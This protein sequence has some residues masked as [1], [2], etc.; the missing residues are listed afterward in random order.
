MINKCADVIVNWLISCDVLEKADRELYRYAVYSFLFSLYPLLLAVLF[1]I[2][3][4]CIMQAIVVIMPFMIIR[5]FSGGY[6]LKNSLLCLLVSCVLLF[7]CILLSFY[8]TCGWVLTAVTVAAAVSLIC[9]SPID[10]ENRVLEPEE[11][12]RYKK[13]TTGLVVCC[14]LVNGLFLFLNMH[15]LSVCISIG[16]VLPAGL[17]VPCIFKKMTTQRH[18]K[19]Q[20]MPKNVVSG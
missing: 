10:H 16:I 14:L 12:L 18:R 15:T 1:G 8:V 13:I 4:N 9:F 7:L 20:L 19:N 17:Q 5:K 11:R 3:M 6:H 2:S